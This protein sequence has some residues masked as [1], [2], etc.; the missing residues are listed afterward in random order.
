VFN[1]TT[2]ENVEIE[3]Y[4]ASAGRGGPRE[5]GFPAAEG[6]GACLLNNK[7]TKRNRVITLI[8]KST[9]RVVILD[10]NQ[11]RLR[12]M[13]KRVKDWAELLKGQTGRLIMYTLTYRP[14]QYYRPN[15]IRDFMTKIRRYYG[16]R[17]YGY[18]WVAELQAR[19]AIHYHVLLYLKVKTWAREPDKMGWWSWGSTT[20]TTARSAFYLVRYTGKERQ[21]DFDKFPVGCRAFATWLRD[22]RLALQHRYNGLRN[23]MKAIVDS[24]GWNALPFYV[25]MAQSCSTWVAWGFCES[26][27]VAVER[28]VPYIP[29]YHLTEI[30]CNVKGGWVV[31]CEAA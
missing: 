30:A 24:E 31:K 25:K 18:A 2:F 1:N 19:G 20:V 16:D 14:G 11:V 8:D 26:V 9:G 29:I 4:A 5:G 27:E 7:V 21:K 17:L 15:D 10:N 3:P 22:D 6:G 28:I 12:H 23:W 13:Q